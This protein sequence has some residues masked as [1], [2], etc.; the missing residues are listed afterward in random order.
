MDTQHPGEVDDGFAFQHA[1][2]GQIRPEHHEQ[3]ENSF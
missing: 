3:L 2:G 1:V